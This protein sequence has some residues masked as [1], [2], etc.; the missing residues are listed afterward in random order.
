MDSAPL[1][2]V[3]RAEF[4]VGTLLV[5]RSWRCHT[6]C[7][8]G[9]VTSKRH[10]TLGACQ[11]F[12]AAASDRR[13]SDLYA[14]FSCRRVSSSV[15]DSGRCFMTTRACPSGRADPRQGVEGTAQGGD[16][17]PRGGVEVHRMDQVYALESFVRRVARST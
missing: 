14:C 12:W 1:G 11:A 2:S 17:Y 4:R 9:K 6:F 15:V 8:V 10:I 7:C 5:L 16:Q 13:V 3:F